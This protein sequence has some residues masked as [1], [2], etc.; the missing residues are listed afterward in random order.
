MAERTAASTQVYKEWTMQISPVTPSPVAA[1]ASGA[2]AARSAARTAAA[3]GDDKT[4]TAAANQAE[5]A[6]Q[7]QV[8]SAGQAMVAS[9]AS[10]VTASAVSPSIVQRADSD[11]DGRTGTAAL[12]DGDSAARAAAL[13]VKMASH[14]VNITV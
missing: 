8:S 11:G 1:L 6:T 4:A 14:S 10:R 9:L 13:Q 12:N 3:T 2:A 5:A 7:V